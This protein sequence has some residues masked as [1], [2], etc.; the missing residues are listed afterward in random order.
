MKNEKPLS[1][2]EKLQALFVVKVHRVM[3]QR[4]IVGK[5]YL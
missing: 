5:R 3:P 2:V 1:H 4:M